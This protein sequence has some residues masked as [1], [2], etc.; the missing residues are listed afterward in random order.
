[1]PNTYTQIYIHLVFSVK[2]RESLIIPELEADLHKMLTSIL[3]N[4]RHT[5]IAIGGMPDHVHLFFGMHPDE[6]LSHLVKELK[7]STT[8]WINGQHKLRG[9]FS[10]QEGYGSFSY[11]QS[12]ID[13]VANYIRRQREHHTVVSFRDEYI[14][15]LNMYGIKYDEQYLFKW[16]T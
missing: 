13:A 6:A 15:I 10:W 9:H 2:N 8:A 5:L 12:Q 1:M 7:T 4:N 16:I 11:S 14:K 3:N